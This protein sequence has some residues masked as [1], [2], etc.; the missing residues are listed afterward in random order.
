[1]T[2]EYDGAERGEKMTRGYVMHY[3]RNVTRG[4]GAVCGN[5]S[6]LIGSD[7]IEDTT[8]KKCLIVLARWKERREAKIKNAQNAQ[9]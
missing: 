2:I 1:M 9:N 7:K 4:N 6:G 5:Q 3:C 8:C